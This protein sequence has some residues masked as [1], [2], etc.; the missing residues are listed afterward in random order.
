MVIYIFKILVRKLKIT[1]IYGAVIKDLILH[2]QPYRFRSNFVRNIEINYPNQRYR[3]HYR[4]INQI[5]IKYCK[6]FN[7]KCSINCF[8]LRCLTTEFI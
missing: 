3:G 7:E 5:N 8:L 2:N 1:K 6:F 4:K